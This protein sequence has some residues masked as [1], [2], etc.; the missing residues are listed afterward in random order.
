MKERPILFSSDM[1]RA[2]L[3]G[4]KA[5]TRRILKKQ[6]IDI[7]PMNIANEWVTL[8]TA[9]PN[10]GS[11]IK[12]RFGVPGD[13]LWVRETWRVWS[14]H[15]GEPI[16]VQFK[17]DMT[18]AAADN[19]DTIPNKV[20]DQIP[21]WEERMWIE[22]SEELD[23]LGLKLD[24][25]DYY[26]FDGDYPL[27]WRPSIHMPRWAS[28]ILLEIIDVRVERIQDISDEDILA[29]GPPGIGIVPMN[30]AM[31]LTGTDNWEDCEMELRHSCFSELW[32]SIYAK[33]GFPWDSNPWV[34]V[35]EFERLEPNNVN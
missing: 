22:S 3:D 33:R 27:K 19:T 30:I 16:D 7:L 5:Q 21:D 20:F 29:E 6:P 12:C 23:A 11:I 1:V 26:I 8:D 13:R 4:R 31:L 18:H 24:E 32:D 34:W 14:W 35:I 9:N 15:E 17:A 10:H 28:R 25:E 2:I